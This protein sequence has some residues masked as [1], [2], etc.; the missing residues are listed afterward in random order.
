MAF[1]SDNFVQNRINF[2][3]SGTREIIRCDPGANTYG[4]VI[5]SFV[6]KK[7]GSTVLRSET[8]AF[9]RD[10]SA[11]AIGAASVLDSLLS[12]LLGDVTMSVTTD[13]TSVVLSVDVNPLDAG[14]WTV[15]GHILF[16]GATE[17]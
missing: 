3:G 10:G 4:K 11:M 17:I 8:R 6:A 2:T 12:G 14:A 5:L 1:L 15:D 9:Y 7:S 16:D 13:D